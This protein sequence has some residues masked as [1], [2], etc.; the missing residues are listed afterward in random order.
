MTIKRSL[1]ASAIYRYYWGE[2]D[3]YKIWVV[4][5]NRV[6]LKLLREFLYGGN[7]QR[8]PFIPV[9]EIWIDNAVSCE[10]FELTLVHELNERDRM[11]KTGCTYLQA[12]N[13][14]LAIEVKLRRK[15][16]QIC[17]DHEK[18]LPGMPV[19][20]YE[21]IK[22]IEDIPN[23]IH[24][25][26]IYRIPVGKREGIAV[27]IVDGYLVRK[28]IYPDFGFSGNDLSD[29]FI[30][31]KEI[32]IDGQ[33]SCEETE[34]SIATELMERRL[35]AKHKGYEYSYET[36]IKDDKEK[37]K[38]MDRQVRRH[39]PVEIPHSSTRDSGVINP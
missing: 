5:G 4:D 28:E 17:R 26:N 8:Y 38:K 27:W 15:F 2:R 6:R 13:S 3:G 23:T 9:G 39:P 18:S 16:G 1:P 32:W 30:P 12:H 14:S 34:Y 31:P 25:R 29:H 37:R 24:L 22:E 7:E 19:T 35:M 20:D 11:A 36:A 10:E 21:N 33:I